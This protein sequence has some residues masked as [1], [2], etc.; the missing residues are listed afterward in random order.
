VIGYSTRLLYI[1][2]DFYFNQR[3]IVWLVFM[4]SS[5]G[6]VFGS[7]SPLLYLVRHSI[8]QLTDKPGGL[9]TI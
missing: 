2:S 1:N 9:T 3:K 8:S 7:W 5:L 4:Y 6:K